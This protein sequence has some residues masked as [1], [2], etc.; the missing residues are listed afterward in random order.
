MSV[1]SL[2]KYLRRVLKGLGVILEFIAMMDAFVLGHCHSPLVIACQDIKQE[3]SVIAG[4]GLGTVF[5]KVVSI[6]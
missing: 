5:S 4:Q 3:R 2:L 1:V 6:A